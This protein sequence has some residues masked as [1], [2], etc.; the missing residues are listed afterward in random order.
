MGTH[1]ISYSQSSAQVINGLAGQA[2]TAGDLLSNAETGYLTVASDKLGLAFEN[3]ITQGPVAIKAI[4]NLE[5][6]SNHDY[7]MN[8]IRRMAALDNGNIAVVYSGNGTNDSYNLNL[9]ILSPLGGD[10]VAKSTLTTDTCYAYRCLKLNSSKFLVA[11]ITGAAALRFIVF[12]ND[13][14]VAVAAVTV[15]TL[16]SSSSSHWNIGLLASGQIVLAYYKSGGNCCFSRYAVD[17]VL[18][19]SETIIEAAANPLY[20]AVLGCSSGDFVVT[21]FR[22]AATTAH[23]LARYT[24]AGVIVG[25]VVTVVTGGSILTSG[26]HTNGLIDLV[27]GNVVYAS[28]SASSSNITVFI[29]SSSNVLIK[30]IDL[31]S[32]IIAVE[33]PQLIPLNGGGFAVIGRYGAKTNLLTFDASGNGIMPAT[34]I[35]GDGAYSATSAGSGVTAFSMGAAGFVVLRAGTNGT[36]Y[37]VRLF[38]VSPV[39]TLTG[40]ELVLKASDATAIYTTSAV[41]LPNGVLAVAYKGDTGTSLLRFGVYNVIRR[42]IIGVAAESVAANTVV[43]ALTNGTIPI[44]QSFGVG[45]NF[46]NTATVI[47]GAK[48]SVVGNTAILRG[49]K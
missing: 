37:D 30:S 10:V 20:F 1:I 23:K 35:G 46:D 32:S 5:S 7:G 45:A 39:G 26:D 31:T 15:A 22:G 16:G 28:A 21:Y 24:G 49:T 33:V 34:P 18:Q 11:W 12:N 3:N 48:G 13:G 19:G 17:G 2:I 42:S 40:S 4:A 47:P 14:S 41:L 9:R 43:R 38:T 44:N 8:A 36:N 25:A 6:A 29:Y 27:S